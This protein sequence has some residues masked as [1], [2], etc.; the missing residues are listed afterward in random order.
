MGYRSCL[1]LVRLAGK[2][3]LPRLEAAAARAL[4]FGAYSMHSVQSMLQHHLEDQPLCLPVLEPPSVVHD[5]IR[6]AAYFDCTLS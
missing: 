3:T 1:G 5:N 4:H 2:Y 6:G